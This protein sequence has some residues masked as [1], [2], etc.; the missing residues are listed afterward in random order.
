MVEISPH[1]SCLVAKKIEYKDWKR[2]EKTA[3]LKNLRRKD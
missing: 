1:N 3:L 2:K